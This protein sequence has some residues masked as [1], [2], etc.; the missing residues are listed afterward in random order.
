MTSLLLQKRLLRAQM[1]SLQPG[2]HQCMCVSAKQRE[3]D[4]CASFTLTC[5]GLI[6]ASGHNNNNKQY[7][8]TDAY[9]KTYMHGYLMHPYVINHQVFWHSLTGK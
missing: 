3:G 2:P 7:N 6:I 4:L 1:D 5:D 8:N 9:I